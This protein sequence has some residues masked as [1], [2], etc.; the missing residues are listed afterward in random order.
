[1]AV[2]WVAAHGAEALAEGRIPSLLCGVP[3][4]QRLGNCAARLPGV[5]LSLNVS[6]D[7]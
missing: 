2:L 6:A 3:S 5:F 4:A 1:M 7:F